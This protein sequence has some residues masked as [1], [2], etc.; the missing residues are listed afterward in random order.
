MSCMCGGCS[1]CLH[2]QGYDCERATCERCA[3]ERAAAEERE[4]IAVRACPDCG[5][6]TGGGYCA[7]CR[8]ELSRREGA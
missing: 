1:R 3:R 2:D 5:E 8:E 7:N 4:E 6:E